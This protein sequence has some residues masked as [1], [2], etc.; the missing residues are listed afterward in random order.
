MCRS[1]TTVRRRAMPGACECAQPRESRELRIRWQPSADRAPGT[2]SRDRATGPPRIA[3]GGAVRA[4]ILDVRE[5]GDPP[6]RVQH[7]AA[8]PE[9]IVAIA[10][11]RSVSRKTTRTDCYGGIPGSP[12][13]DA[14]GSTLRLDSKPP[15]RPRI[16]PP[17]VRSNPWLRICARRP[18]VGRRAAV[19]QRDLAEEVAGPELADRRAVSV[20][21]GA[22]GD[23]D[24]EGGPAS[25]WRTRL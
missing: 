11:R 24:E 10:G 15:Q 7:L 18:L 19:D 4:L 12:S 23:D 1:V 16:R 25:P 13:G 20:H 9:P 22:T 3:R 14:A 6:A 8:L 5:D 21:T 2:C 17:S